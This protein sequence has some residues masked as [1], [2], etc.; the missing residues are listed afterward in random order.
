MKK[1]L[2]FLFLSA[3]IL[4]AQTEDKFGM[5]SL[6]QAGAI[7]VTIG[8]DFIVTGS[9]PAIVTERVDQFV[10]RIYKQASEKLIASINDPQQLEE[11]QKKIDNF[12]LRGITLKR[13]SGEVQ[14]LDLQKFR[15]NGDFKNNPYLKNDD[16][17]IFPDNDIER[18]FFTVEGAVN[19][20]NIF[21]YVDG[22]NLQDALEL[23]RGINK[24]YENVDSVNIYRLSYDGEKMEIIKSDISGHT[25]LKEGTE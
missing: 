16:V 15:I 8:G 13:S 21:F 10:S 23:A 5:N 18:N 19:N 1:I 7:S 25:L 11:L 22:D 12:S 4:N 17:I 9:F 3:L 6:L 20:P 2:L 14:N 24:A